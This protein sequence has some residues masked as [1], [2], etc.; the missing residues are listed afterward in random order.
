M[1]G[2]IVN[3][4]LEATAPIARTSPQLGTDSIR[5]CPVPIS[6]IF[7]VE[8][9]ALKTPGWRQEGVR[10]DYERYV[11]GLMNAVSVW[12]GFGDASK[13]DQQKLSEAV[14][15]MDERE[16]FSFILDVFR[17]DFGATY[18]G[19][20]LLTSAIEA[21][22]FNCY[23]SSVLLADALTRLGKPVS[24]F[25][26]PDH[27]LLHGDRYALETTAHSD[28]VYEKILYS[29]SGIWREI[30]N[31][32]LLAI[33]YSWAGKIFHDRREIDNGKLLAIAYSWA[34]KIF[35][36]RK[37]LGEE[38]EAYNMAISLDP[39]DATILYNKG[40]VLYD[41]KR[42]GEALEV[43]NMVISLFPKFASAWYNKGSAL[44]AI[45]QHTEAD[46]CYQKANALALLGSKR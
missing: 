10:K 2:T 3:A 28:G 22:T 18:K 34:G 12:L 26:R 16:L 6:S 44:S 43:Y 11:S 42:F 37:L 30:D 1:Y 9:G 19:G 5:L 24:I 23:S 15:S 39:N 36:G 17:K 46:M 20:M 27:V 33:A 29:K 14:K 38:L 41:M 45:G 4:K 32:K 40:N 21:N 7:S 13:A 35:H 31:G 8:F 25:L